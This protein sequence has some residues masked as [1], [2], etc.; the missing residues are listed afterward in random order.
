M[1]G[2]SE[3]FSGFAVKD[4]Q[5]AKDF[6]GGTLGLTLADV[7]DAAPLMR[8]Q[9]AGGREVLIYEQRSSTPA[10]YT[11]L[12]FPVPDVE[13]AVAELAGKG[14]TLERYDG[15]GQDE[16][17]IARDAGPAIGWFTDPSGNVLSVLQQD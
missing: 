5:K 4:L 11:I 15:L 1:L 17:G 3:A 16:Q 2:N 6:Y 12:N 13:A 14:V 8:L 10:S 7:P 9:L